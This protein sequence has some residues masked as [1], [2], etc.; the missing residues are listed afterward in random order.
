VS[1]TTKRN[2]K[3]WLEELRARV[4]EI[5]AKDAARIWC[6]GEEGARRRLAILRGPNV[7]ESPYRAWAGALPDSFTV[8]DAQVAWGMKR[9]S[10]N[11]RI[12]VLQRER[13]VWLDK[14]RVVVQ[15][16]GSSPAIY[17]RVK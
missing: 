3:E 12:E 7:K 4:L 17:R 16:G 8:L 11:A 9:S 1:P 13:L 15:G 5:S 6:I 14:K 2:R 10:A